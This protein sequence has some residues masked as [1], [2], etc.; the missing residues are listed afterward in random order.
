MVSFNTVRVGST[1][2][3]IA[4]IL[5]LLCASTCRPVS[6]REFVEVSEVNLEAVPDR[7]SMRITD[8]AM[9]RRGIV[10]ICDRTRGH[11]YR[12]STQTNEA[13]VV[14]P[15]NLG[16]GKSWRPCAIAVDKEGML[17]VGGENEVWIFDMT[18]RV[19]KNYNTEIDYPTS[20][21]VM[22]NGTIY[23]AGENDGYIL[24][25]Y[26]LNGHVIPVLGR[27]VKD[28]PVIIESVSGG[29]VRTWE[30]GVLF[31]ADT[32]YEIVAIGKAG[33]VIK[34]QLRPEMDLAPKVAFD[35]SGGTA[36]VQISPSGRGLSIA[37][38]DSLIYYCFSPNESGLYTDVTRVHMD[39]YDC[40]FKSI[41]KDINIDGVILAADKDGYFY[42]TK[43]NNREMDGL[44]RGKFKCRW[45]E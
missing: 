27:S 5:I 17:Y 38:D 3:L 7:K 30:G 12:V 14:R 10:Y 4:W 28:L 23:V 34:R 15:T 25:Q 42:F 20:I 45:N 2:S 32:P 37:T 11:V 16:K 21:A 43:K 1:H 9:G 22:R 29:M 36:T 26:D 39:V 8:V 44:F 18:G 24:H 31:G 19:I 41:A 33:N 35:V 13:N 6:A 40:H